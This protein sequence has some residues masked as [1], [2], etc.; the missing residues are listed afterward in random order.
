M[1]HPERPLAV[2]Q[3]S[4]RYERLLRDL[5]DDPRDVVLVLA[6]PPDAQMILKAI[7]AAL[8]GN[9]YHVDLAAIISKY[10]GE[11]EKNLQRVFDQVEEG[12]VLVFD[13][14]DAL[15][16]QRPEVADSHRRFLEL[17]ADQ[18]R[19]SILAAD[20]RVGDVREVLRGGPLPKAVILKLY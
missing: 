1:G 15:F 7:V 13:E 11:T 2:H 14:A 6:A 12:Q 5:A 17:L 10:I 19:L 9:P 20:V 18:P 16:D 8:D 3:G 4:R